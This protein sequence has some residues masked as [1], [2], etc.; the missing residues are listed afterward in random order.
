MFYSYVIF[1]AILK[2]TLSI[3]ILDSDYVINRKLSIFLLLYIF[4]ILCYQSHITFKHKL[5]FK[6]NIKTN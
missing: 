3:I 2:T 6:V 5:F 4:F 1:E